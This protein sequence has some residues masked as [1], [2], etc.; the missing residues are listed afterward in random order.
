MSRFQ[1]KLPLSLYGLTGGIGC[2][3]ST[4]G[5]QFELQ[6]IPVIDADK[7]GHKVI[8]P[9]G[10][11]EIAVIRY[12]GEVILTDGIIDRKKLGNIIFNAPEKRAELNALVHPAIYQEVYNACGELADT[13]FRVALMDAALLGDAGSVDPEFSGLILVLA[14]MEIRKARLQH[15]RGLTEAE[16]DTRMASQVPPE[17]KIPLAT[18]IIYNNHGLD[19]LYTQID[20]IVDELNGRFD[21]T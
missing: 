1:S 4:A 20:H 16:V 15:S 10:C 21:R 6:G 9:G 19:E 3:K 17:S 12:F 14:D 11:A 18:W 13:G 2:G 5:L 8:A 7:L